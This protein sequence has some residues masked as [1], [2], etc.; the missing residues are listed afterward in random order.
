MFEAASDAIGRL[1]AKINRD[2]RQNSNTTMRTGCCAS[3]ASQPVQ[4]NS[5]ALLKRNWVTAMTCWAG[6]LRSLPQALRAGL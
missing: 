5:F 2:A 3:N 4:A 6:S 1:I